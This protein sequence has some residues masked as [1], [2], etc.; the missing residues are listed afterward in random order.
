M[1]KTREFVDTYQEA[2]ALYF[3]IGV[4]KDEQRAVELL[5][6][7]A[8]S[9]M[10]DAQHILSYIIRTDERFSFHG[11]WFELLASSAQAGYPIAQYE[12]GLAY[13]S[14]ERVEAS[15][16]TALAWF[17]KAANQGFSAACTHLGSMYL[18][19]EGVTQNLDTALFWLN[20]KSVE[21]TQAG[22]DFRTAV[23]ELK[24]L[25]LTKLH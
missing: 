21:K 1:D 15:A 6:D 12:L 20:N 3:G 22:I 24:Q 17:E 4:P 10:P 14:G 25:Q 23:E 19:G 8:W 9:G 2:E 16:E 13:L 7:C 18:F 11:D 5:T